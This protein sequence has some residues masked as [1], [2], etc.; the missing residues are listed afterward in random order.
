MFESLKSRGEG[1]FIPFVTLGDPNPEESLAILR[2]LAE[3]GADALELGIPFSD[4]IADGP[5]IQTAANRA[6]EA[7]VTPDAC[8]DMIK[9]VREEYGDLPIG[10]LV[11]ANLVVG[12]GIA[13]FYRRG[14]DSGVDSVLIAD[15]PVAPA[16][17][18]KPAAAAAGVDQV[19][20]VPPN[21]D[22]DTLRTV[23]ERA[24]GYVY[25][26]GRGGVTGAD[27]EMS[28]PDSRMIAS[29]REYGSPPIVVGFGISRP[30]HVR[31]ALSAG[32]DGAISGS[33]V[34]AAIEKNLGDKD[35]LRSQLAKFVREMKSAAKKP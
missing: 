17:I 8:F 33:A 34:V 27:K 18:F 6:L 1:A 11:Y 26:L 32:A 29:L 35:E 5:V 15:A 12:G 31:A 7:G 22:A 10:L 16:P 3:N 19:Y 21:A 20:I 4:P 23:A 9:R 25:F 24:E 2:V 28:A 30:E 14:S 13:N